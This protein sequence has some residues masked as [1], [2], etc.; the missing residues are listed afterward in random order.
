MPQRH[1]CCPPACGVDT[2][3]H[4]EP[5]PP[6]VILAQPGQCQEVGHLQE[7]TTRQ[8]RP[9]TLLRRRCAG[10]CCISAL[11]S[12]LHVANMHNCRRTICT[13]IVLGTVTLSPTCHEKSAA[14]SIHAAGSS[15]PAAAA[16]PMRGGMAPTT[17]PTHVFAML[18]CL[19][20]VYTP[21]YS[22]MLAAPRAVVRGLVCM[23]GTTCVSTN[24]RDA[25]GVVCGV[26]GCGGVDSV[27]GP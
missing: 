15:S 3:Q 19:R 2:R 9:R 25:S 24:R 6:V 18:S 16:Q 10:L 14:A 1:C 17:A 4:P 27:Q 21:A 20:G 5:T 11:L 8:G 7:G 22:T 23:Q 12:C 13:S 26:G